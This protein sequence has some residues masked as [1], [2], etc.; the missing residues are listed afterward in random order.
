MPIRNSYI[1]VLQD[2]VFTAIFDNDDAVGDVEK[3]L[4]AIYPNPVRDGAVFVTNGMRFE[5]SGYEVSDVTGRIVRHGH[6]NSA[7]GIRVDGLA[8]GV[9]LLRIDG[10]YGKF[11]M[12]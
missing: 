9:Y 7:E 5:A 4:V 6:Y 8:K 11:V 2:T 1:S 10:K 3:E 12:E